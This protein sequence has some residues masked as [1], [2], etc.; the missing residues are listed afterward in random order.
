MNVAGVG[1]D[2]GFDIGVCGVDGREE[3]VGLRLGNHGGLERA[4]R[5]V[6]DWNDFTKVGHAFVIEHGTA[7]VGRA[8]YEHDQLAKAGIE[9]LEPLSRSASV[10][11]GDERRAFDEVGLLEIVLRHADAPGGGASVQCGYL[12][13]I[14]LELEREGFGNSFA[15]EVVFGGS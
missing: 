1:E 7:F 15:R 3:L 9:G 4:F 8:G 2:G 6:A 5:D 12:R 14:A 13:G 11:V 10:G